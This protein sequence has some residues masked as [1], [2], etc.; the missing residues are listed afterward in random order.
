MTVDLDKFDKDVY[1]D[2]LNSE[3]QRYEITLG[4]KVWNPWQIKE[5]KYEN[6]LLD[7]IIEAKAPFCS[8]AKPKISP[9]TKEISVFSKDD[10][11]TKFDQTQL[12]GIPD[13]CK[14]EVIE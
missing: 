7:I 9:A 5:F 11:K 3:T 6:L 13:K 8:D 10:Y 2:Y 4:F 14:I 1:K 12:S